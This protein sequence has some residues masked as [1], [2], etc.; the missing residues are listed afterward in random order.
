[1]ETAVYVHVPVCRQKCRY[2]AF[3][4]EPLAEV[5]RWLD[6][7]LSALEREIAMLNQR[8]GGMV[9]ARTFFLGGGTPTALDTARLERLL[10]VLQ[11]GLCFPAGAEKSVEVNPGTL[12]ARKIELLRRFGV[13]RVSLGVQ[14]FDDAVLRRIGRIHTAAQA[15]QGI[16]LIRAAG[17]PQLDV[18]LDL[19]FGLPGQGMWEWRNSVEQ[20]LSY[21]PEHLSLYGLILEEGTPL[22]DAYARR[23]AGELWDL[24]DED[25][26][27]DMYDWASDRLRRAGYR[28][29]ETANF[30]LPGREC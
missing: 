22:G 10:G 16:A 7:Y 15:A 4:S 9:T 1:M 18:N 26:Q 17:F 19:M 21:A 13:N 27:A 14:S 11:R 29:Y 20:A 6:G 30:A 3:Y 24:P 12:T 28:R 8:L 5:S 2:C 25:A 23:R